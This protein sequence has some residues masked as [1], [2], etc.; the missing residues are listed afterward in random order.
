MK[1]LI[2]GTRVCQIEEDAD[3]FP[4]LSGMQ[5]VDCDS[6]IK[7]DH[8]TYVDG[9]FVAPTISNDE[10]LAA[11]RRERTLRLQSSDWTQAGDSQLSNKAAWATYRQSLR[12]LPANTADPSDVTWPDE[13]S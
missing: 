12:D 6:S 4:V 8:H 2:H 13:P 5:W 10:H 1:A 9:S 11:L 7:V 3:V